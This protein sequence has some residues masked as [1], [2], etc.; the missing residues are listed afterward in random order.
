MSPC[1]YFRSNQRSPP[2]AKNN[3]MD[4][5]L[6]LILAAIWSA[7]YIV[8]KIGVATLYPS[9]RARRRSLLGVL[10]LGEALTGQQLIALTLIIGSVHPGTSKR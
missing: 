1:S 9:S 8:I 4:I 3:P 5:A 6:W 7:S 10:L 2:N